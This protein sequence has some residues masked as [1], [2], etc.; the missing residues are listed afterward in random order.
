M[1]HPTETNHN[2]IDL[3]TGR[4]IN[5]KPP[6]IIRIAPELNGMEML[7]SNDTA[8]D[9]LF[10]IKLAAWGL[11]EDGEIFGL[12]PWLDGIVPCHEICDPLNGQFEGYRDPMIDDIFYV[13]PVHKALEL[14]SA[15]EYYDLGEAEDA[16][17]IQEIPDTIGTHA[18]CTHNE[19]RTFSLIEVLSW[20]LMGDGTILGMLVDED[21]V[22]TTPVLPGDPCLYPAQEDPNFKYFFQHRIANK[23][24][25]EDPEA[26]AALSLL[27]EP[28]S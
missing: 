4:P 18:V 27:M 24:K 28:S 9:K 17:I 12:V 25:E 7:Y 1:S 13:P 5:D 2:V 10:S 19:F 3:F 23:I 16:S 21:R 22:A 14:E 6:R 15:A 11:R 20:R 8:H 26:L